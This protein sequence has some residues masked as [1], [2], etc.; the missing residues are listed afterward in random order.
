MAIFPNSLLS[1]ASQHVLGV[2]NGGSGER[3][4]GLKPSLVGHA[5]IEMD[6]EDF[7]GKDGILE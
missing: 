4:P 3:E 6:F 1:G 2:N 7:K 5:S